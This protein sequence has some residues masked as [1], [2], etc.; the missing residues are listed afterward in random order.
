MR[1]LKTHRVEKMMTVRALA[2]ASGVSPTTLVKI[3]HGRVRPHYSTMLAV[4]R[5]LGVEPREVEEFDA[6]LESKIAEAA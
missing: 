5:A 6:A 1:P 3:E 2:T 4:A